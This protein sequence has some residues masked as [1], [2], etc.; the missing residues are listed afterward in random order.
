MKCFM[1]KGDMINKNTNYLS[2]T[3]SAKMASTSG[4]FSLCLLSVKII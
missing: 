2:K 3:L 1:C 4:V